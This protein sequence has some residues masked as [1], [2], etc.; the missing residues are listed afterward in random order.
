MSRVQKSDWGKTPQGKTVEV[1]TLTNARGMVAKV[2]TWGATLT[3][4]HVP[5]RAGK[6]A[7]VVLGFDTFEP[8]LTK[9]P[10]FGCTTG[11]VANRIANGRFT[12]GGKEYTLATN[13]DPN[14]LHGG[15][16]GLDKRL[17]EAS[18]LP[19]T[20]GAAVLFKYTSP[21]G[22]EGY[23]GALAI[24]VTYTLTET[25]ELIVD[26]HATTTATTPVNLTNHAYFN[27]AG[28]GNGT[29]LDHKLELRAG[30][31]TPVDET[32][33]PSGE[34]RS[35][36]G[37]VM[38]FT[39]PMA[40]GIRID[41]LAGEPGGYDHNYC[42]DNQDGDLALAARL[43][44]PNSGRVLEILTT[45]P[46]IQLYTGNFLDGSIT[47]KDGVTY[48]KNYAVCLETQHYPDSVNQP[49]FPSTILAPG[50]TYTQT[51]V[52]RFSAK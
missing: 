15:I 27:L 8:F 43:V 34:I 45:E 33:I 14:H 51:T 52:H 39:T 36:K 3:E 26:Y 31:Y 12:L 11:R 47:G 41:K 40:I 6:L 16:A 13:N 48:L 5:D 20:K 37:T 1:Y 46:G 38:D 24:A 4:L 42:L 9:S 32:G 23:P 7:D 28:A 49:N 22:E 10:Y 25:N 30:H 35:V 21:D 19:S 18:I 17:W 50:A 44:E 2:M 29:I